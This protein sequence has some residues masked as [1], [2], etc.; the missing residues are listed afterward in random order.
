[1]KKRLFITSALMTAVMAASLATGTY[2]WYAAGGTGGIKSTTANG[3]VAT[4]NPDINLV[5][6]VEVTA[7]VDAVNKDSTLCLAELVSNPLGADLKRNYKTYYLNKSNE[8]VEYT[9]SGN[10]V[11]SKA[12]TVS[13]TIPNG[14]TDPVVGNRNAELYAKNVSSLLGKTITI[15][16][17]AAEG[18]TRAKVWAS[19]SKNALKDEDAYTVKPNV[20][21]TFPN[22]SEQVTETTVVA[23]VAV[24][25]EGN[26]ESGSEG[27]KVNVP[28]E[29]TIS[30]NFVVTIA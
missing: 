26:H 20:S 27:N 24:Y 22:V 14:P 17:A 30:G 28:D 9:R 7:K 18:A 8:E 12:Y 10:A 25:V 19:D 3:E 6:N 5:G 21:Y 11:A 15:S 23:Y 13:V 16:V 2:A 1:M 4:V 29:G